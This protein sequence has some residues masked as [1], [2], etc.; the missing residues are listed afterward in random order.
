VN[1]HEEA[2]KALEAYNREVTRQRDE[3]KLFAAEYHAWVLDRIQHAAED[4]ENPSDPRWWSES[5]D[6]GLE[7]LHRAATLFGFER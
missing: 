6:A 3:T 1:K 5:D 4:E 7:L 2:V